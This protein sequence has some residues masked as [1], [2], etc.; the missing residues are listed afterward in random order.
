MNKLY[1]CNKKYDKIIITNKKDKNPALH[2]TEILSV[3]KISGCENV[4]EV[5]KIQTLEKQFRQNQ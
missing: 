2:M 3:M 4:S 1:T 5:W